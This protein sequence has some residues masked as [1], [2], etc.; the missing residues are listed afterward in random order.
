MQR[1]LVMSGPTAV[2]CATQVAVVDV[3]NVHVSLMRNVWITG[4]VAPL[5][6]FVTCAKILYVRAF[7]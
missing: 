4:V 6:S 3:R 2:K 5:G 7:Y 1:E